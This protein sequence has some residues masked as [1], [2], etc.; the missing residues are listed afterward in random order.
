[1]SVSSYKTPKRTSCTTVQMLQ[2]KTS[3]IYCSYCKNLF[4]LETISSVLMVKVLFLFY[5][6][7]LII[8]IPSFH[9]LQK[10]LRHT[11]QVKCTVIYKNQ[12]LKRCPCDLCTILCSPCLNYYSIHFILNELLSVC[13]QLYK[14]IF[15]NCSEVYIF[16]SFTFSNFS[17]SV[18][19]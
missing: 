7:I 13:F 18:V 5:L 8:V 6:L 2:S 15:Q 4:L 11:I 16:F 3:P 9:Y 10:D 14:S 17:T 1:M 12:H 19:L